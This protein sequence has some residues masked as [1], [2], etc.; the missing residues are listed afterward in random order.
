MTGD[1]V[2]TLGNRLTLRRWVVERDNPPGT[3]RRTVEVHGSDELFSDWRM[4]MG[5][6]AL[7]AGQNRYHVF[8]TLKELGPD[9]IIATYAGWIELP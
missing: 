7:P 2:L 3:I 8:H 4:G 6:L 5:V 9:H 1:K